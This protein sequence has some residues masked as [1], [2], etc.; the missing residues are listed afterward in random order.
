MQLV[1][2]G[3]TYEGQW[4]A[5]QRHGSGKANFTLGGSYEGE[6]YKG[7]M[8][9]KGK[10]V[11]S[12]GRSHVG[13]FRDGRAVGAATPAPAPRGEQE[14]FGLKADQ[15][16]T[17][18]NMLHNVAV[19]FVPLDAAW[20]ALS[21]AEKA[22]LRSHY[23]ALDEGDEPPYPLK[24]T[25]A[26]VKAVSGLY[27]QFTDYRGDALV[28]V[29]VGA[30]GIPTHASTDGVSHREFARY[31]SMLAMMQRFKPALCAGKPCA[32]IFPIKFNFKRE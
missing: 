20:E 21:P 12:S 10:I 15:P 24:G 19:G 18:S 5:D 29:T 27:S 7:R 11:Y 23:P 3:S 6:W 13:E 31:L 22:I 14:R 8:H 17:G 9:G 16:L 26:F 30:D 1:L 4:H 32:M 25:R 28:Y 2:D